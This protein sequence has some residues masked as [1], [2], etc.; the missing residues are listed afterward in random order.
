MKFE[1]TGKNVR[2]YG[3]LEETIEEKLEK[4]DKY[5]SEDSDAKVMLTKEGNRKKIEVTIH[6]KGA[7]F[8]AEDICDD[9]Y[10]G[11]DSV[12]DKLASQMSK[13][14]GRMKR[15]WQDNRSVR[16]ESIP[17]PE[18]NEDTGGKIIKTKRFNLM[19]MT[20]EEAVLQM[21]MLQH[22]FFIY[23]DMDTDSVNAVYSRKDG[24][25]GVLETNA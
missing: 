13:F 25:Y 3:K 11:I 2:V 6:T 20:R 7:V 5:F 17:E 9:V 14:K 22:D 1:I 10:D 15:R 21:E 24:N 12:S 16:F 18:E 4:L 8:R 19:P 23:L